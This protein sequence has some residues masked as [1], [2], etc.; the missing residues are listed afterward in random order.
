MLRAGPRWQTMRLMRIMHTRGHLMG[1]QARQGVIYLG[2]DPGNTGALVALGL[3][4]GPRVL[5]MP[6]INVGT[7]KR[8]RLVLDEL[9]VIEWLE[10][11]KTEGSIFAAIEVQ[12]AMP[13]QGSASGFRLGCSYG[14][15]CAILTTLRISHVRI[16][17][18]EWQRVMVGTI[19]QGK[20]RAVAFCRSV[21]PDVELVPKGCRVPQDGI[22]DAACMAEW[23][24]Q[25]GE[26]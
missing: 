6:T 26:L 23:A 14:A 11:L 20:A 21:M 25:R 12:Q 15:L 18:R 3:R 1:A 10:E 24:R 13:K 17:S 7:K 5:R 9:A 4:D 16:R 19:G 8:K 22:A 2:V